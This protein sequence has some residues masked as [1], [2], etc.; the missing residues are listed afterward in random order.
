[1]IQIAPLCTQR[2]RG[3]IVATTAP[4]EDSH[5]EGSCDLRDMHTNVP[6]SDDAKRLAIELVTQRGRPM[7]GLHGSVSRRYVSQ[8]RNGEAD[9]QFRRTG[10]EATARLC[11]NHP[12]LPGGR[13]I[14]VVSVVPGL[15][16]NPEI[17]QSLE[18][19]PS[20]FCAFAVR[21][22][23]IESTQCRCIA[24]WTDE[25]PNLGSLPQ[26]SDGLGTLIRLVDIIKNGDMHLLPPLTPDEKGERRAAAAPAK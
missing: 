19:R 16:E 13:Q 7:S 20:E 5:V 2:R 1:M 22:E 17:G 11:H 6:E 23:G 12:A 3:A 8:Q 18:E 25:Y 4:G 26:P 15:R 14:D 21:Y 9:G 24:K 10:G